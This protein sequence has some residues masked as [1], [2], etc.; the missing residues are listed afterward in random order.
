M[1]RGDLEV[2]EGAAR[3][4]E[5]A[6]SATPRLGCQEQTAGAEEASGLCCD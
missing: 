3:I 6:A 1:L 5:Q 2:G 4:P